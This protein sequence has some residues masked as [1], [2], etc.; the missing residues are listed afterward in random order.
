MHLVILKKN[1][2]KILKSIDKIFEFRHIFC[3]EYATNI[4]LELEL[5]EDIYEDSKIFLLHTNDYILSIIY[6]DRNLSLDEKMNK[7]EKELEIEESKLHEVINEIKKVKDR[8]G[9]KIE[10]LENVVNKWRDYREVK[11]NFFLSLFKDFSSNPLPKVNSKLKLTKQLIDE[12]IE[13]W[14]LKL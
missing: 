9:F 10:D 11:A 12:F 6:P 14:D 8:Y 4:E 2:N 7:T 1:Y 13:E 5:I 3:H